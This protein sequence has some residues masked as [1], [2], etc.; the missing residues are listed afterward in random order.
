[1]IDPL[2][3]TVSLAILAVIVIYDVWTLLR[4][5][6]ATTISWNL[7]LLSLRFPIIPAAIGVVIGHLFWPNR[8]GNCP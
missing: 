3:L 8:A 6:Y 7:Y 2:T 1:M 5:G 4:R